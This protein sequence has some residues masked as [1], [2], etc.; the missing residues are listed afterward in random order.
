MLRYLAIAVVAG[1][2]FTLDTATAAQICVGSGLGLEDVAAGQCFEDGATEILLDKQV[3]AADGSAMVLR[4]TNGAQ[5]RDVRTCRDYVQLS[6]NGDWTPPG[7]RFE[8]VC[9]VASMLRGTKPAALSHLRPGNDDLTD[10][11]RLTALVL[12]EMGDLDPEVAPDPRSVAELIKAGEASLGKSA[13]PLTLKH[14]GTTAEYRE[15]ARGDVDNDGIEDL[16]LERISTSAD[17]TKSTD[18]VLVTRTDADGML[19][20]N[21]TFAG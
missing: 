4:M 14:K 5:S 18:T 13:A 20:L 2:A 19:V 8:Y 6:Q 21:D 9:S 11:T 1:G 7:E 3:L 12:P 17:G 16:L 15:L 10:T